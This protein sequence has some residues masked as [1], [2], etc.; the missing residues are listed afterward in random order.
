MELVSKTKMDRLGNVVF[1][2]TFTDDTGMQIEK[3]VS[4]EDYLKMLGEATKVTEPMTRI[5]ALPEHYYDGALS[6]NNVKVVLFYPAARRTVLFGSKHWSVPFPNLI[7]LISTKDKKRTGGYCFAI[8]TDKPNQDTALFCYPFG[9]VSSSGSICF[10]NIESKE[11]NLSNIENVVDDFF[12]GVTNNDYYG[13]GGE[14]VVPVYK[15]EELLDKLTKMDTF[16]SEWL[17]ETSAKTK[18]LGEICN[19]LTN[20]RYLL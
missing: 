4:F 10:G 20:E 7:F 2:C 1:Q 9:N 12:C 13:D 17:K 18:T 11:V 14:L 8:G 6:N 19:A 15:Q 16:P 5:G 3:T